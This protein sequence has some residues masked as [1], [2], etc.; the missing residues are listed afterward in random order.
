MAVAEEHLPLLDD[1][2]QS[3]FALHEP[4]EITHVLRALVEA[5]SIITAN[6]IPGGLACPTALLAVDDDGSLVLDGNRNEAMNRRVAGSSRL[7]C[8]TQLDLVPIRFRLSTPMLIEHEGYPAFRV[9]WP[10][11]LLRLQRREMY[12]LQVSPA[13]PATLHV[14][15]LEAP[16]DAGTDGL[17]VL[18]ISG[19]GLA[20]A[21]PEGR[22]GRF[23]AQSRVAPCLLRLGDAPPMTVALEVAHLGRFDVR[24]APYWRAGCRF[25]DM[26]AAHEQRILQ[27]IFQVER[28]R[29]ARQRRGG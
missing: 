29:N 24:G 23:A 19:G 9:P 10:E 7:V 11:T 14:G 25:V 20:V 28:Q 15:T 2:E 17:R 5:R 27:Y 8:S 12:R 21:V 16:P 3:P 4:R 18:D 13:S 6:L 22:E 26:P 1:D